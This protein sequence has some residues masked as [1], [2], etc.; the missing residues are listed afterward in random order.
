MSKNTKINK[1]IKNTIDL[2]K[3]VMKKVISGKISMKPRWYFVV[4]SILSTIGLAALIILSIFLVNVVTFLLR[5]NGPMK[6]WKFEMMVLNFPIWIPI[7]ALLG[8][9][10]GILL[11]KRY[12]FSY[13][14]NFSI[15]IIGFIVAIIISGILI[16]L[17]G[18][19]NVWS[20]RGVMRKFYKRVD[21][22][23]LNIQKGGAL[24][25]RGEYRFP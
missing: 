25:G 24:H 5:S 4:G 18:L 21:S 2:E 11:L 12:D 3:E 20:K 1:N 23:N 19:D 15:I 17:S 22:Q 10:L 9:V 14:N 7:L 8:I 6:Y 16:D 13:K